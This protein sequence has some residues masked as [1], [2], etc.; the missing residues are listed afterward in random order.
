M[1]LNQ[2]IIIQLAIC[3]VIMLLTVIMISPISV[4]ATEITSSEQK[5]EEMYYKTDINNVGPVRFDAEKTDS[6]PGIIAIAII[7]IFGV[8]TTLYRVL[9]DGKYK[10]L[11]TKQN[12]AGKIP[13]N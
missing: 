1:I 9:K 12:Q 2:N 4:F 6:I 11:T 10:L 13:L 5:D 7:I 3:F 8:F